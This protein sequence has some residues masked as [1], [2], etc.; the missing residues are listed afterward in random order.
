LICSWQ[1]CKSTTSPRKTR[2]TSSSCWPSIR[3]R[4]PET[5]DEAELL[6]VNSAMTGALR[7][8]DTQSGARRRIS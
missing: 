3:R 6:P 1:S 5:I 4:G 8:C 7:E 2:S